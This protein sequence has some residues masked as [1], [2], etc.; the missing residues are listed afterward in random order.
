MKKPKK[1]YWYRKAQ[2][3]IK[4]ILK[5]YAAARWLSWHLFNDKRFKET[6]YKGRTEQQGRYAW[7]DAIRDARANQARLRGILT[8]A[9]GVGLMSLMGADERTRG[10]S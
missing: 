4:P 5:E 9:T 6:F 10:E 3:D 7:Y 2:R 1:L 8:K